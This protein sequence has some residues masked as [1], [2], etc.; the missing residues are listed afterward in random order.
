MAKLDLEQSELFV[1]ETRQALGI[2]HQKR[3]DGMTLIVKFKEAGWLADYLRVPDVELPDV[4]A[5]WNYKTRVI[6]LRESVFIGLHPRSPRAI[7]TLTEELMHCARGH[8]GILNRSVKVKA[9]EVSVPKYR[10]METE[11]KNLAAIFLCPEYLVPDLFDVDLLVD[12][13]GISNQ[14]AIY[15]QDEIQKLRRIRNGAKRPIPKSVL[16]YLEE[17]KRRNGIL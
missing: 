1:R 17:A 8:K 6:S 9:Y 4:E 2:E 10:R 13:F 3:P 15:R 11:A 7:M 5:S 16:E 12:Q 14:A